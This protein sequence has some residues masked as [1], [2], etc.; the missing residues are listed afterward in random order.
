MLSSNLRRMDPILGESRE[1]KKGGFVV[2]TR[3][4]A[5]AREGEEGRR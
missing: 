2:W 3:G 1:K 4:K 5:L